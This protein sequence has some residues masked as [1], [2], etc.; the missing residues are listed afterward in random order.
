MTKGEVCPGKAGSALTGLS[1]AIRQ[2]KTQ[3]AGRKCCSWFQDG[4]DPAII[5]AEF[6]RHPGNFGWYS[7][8]AYQALVPLR[9]EVA[10]MTLDAYPVPA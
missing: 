4:A 1:K 3:L 8:P 2:S 7:S 9:D 6:G 5:G 10:E